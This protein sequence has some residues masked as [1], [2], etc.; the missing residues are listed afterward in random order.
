MGYFIVLLELNRPWVDREEMITREQ[1]ESIKSLYREIYPTLGLDKFIIK[2][3]DEGLEF[4][5]KQFK[6]R[7]NNI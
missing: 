6:E 5:V 3:D 7:Q 4:V 2:P 1:N